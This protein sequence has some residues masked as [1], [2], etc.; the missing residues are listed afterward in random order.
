MLSVDGAHDTV[1]LVPVDAIWE[2]PDGA[3]GAWVSAH[4]LVEATILTTLE[5][6]P[7]RLTAA[8]PSV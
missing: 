4:G 1:A 3:D 6:M 5:R 7:V 8:T 2:T